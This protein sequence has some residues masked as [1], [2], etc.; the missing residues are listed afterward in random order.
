MLTHL[1]RVPFICAL[2]LL[3]VS[4]CP[5][6]D[7][8]GQ[9]DAV[10]LDSRSLPAEAMLGHRQS[11]SGTIPYH[12]AVAVSAGGLHT[13][14]LTM[15]GGVKC[16]GDNYY[17]QLGDGT[18]AWG[19]VSN[20]PVDVVG[21][22][23]GVASV[24][25]SGS[26][27]S[28]HTCALTSSG[29][30]K[31]WGLNYS[32]E[33]GDGTTINRA[34]PVDVVGLASD[35]AQLD[36]GGNYTCATTT[37][38]GIKCWGE[39][40]NGQLGDGTSID[41]T[42]PVDVVGLTTGAQ[43]VSAGRAHACAVTSSGSVKCWGSNYAGEL[44]DGTTIDRNTPVDVIG[45]GSGVV[46]VSAAMLHT[47]ALTSSGGVK[48][49]GYN[50]SGELGDGTT[51]SRSTPVDV[52]GLTSG[53]TA[54][55]SGAADFPPYGTGYTCA[56][57]LRGEIKCWGGNG[58]GQLGDGTTISRTM[59]VDVIGLTG[60]VE[61]VTTGAFHT[62]AVTG[63]HQVWCWGSNGAG[64]L[65]N[66]M[67]SNFRT[68]PT[69]TVEMPTTAVSVSAGG[70]DYDGGGHSCALTATS[71]V[72]CWGRNLD[73]ELGDGT[74]NSSDIPVDVVGLA[75]GVIAMTTGRDHACALTVGGGVKCWGNN[76]S[77]QLGDGTWSSRN[78]PVDVVG[79]ASGVTAVDAGGW[80]TCAL[81]TSRGIKCWGRNREGQLGDGTTTSRRT[82]ADVI[83][84][85]SGVVA[86]SSGSTHTCALIEGGGVRC[87]GLNGSGELGD[88][89]TTSRNTPVD[90]VGLP[91]G[92]VAVSA[93]GRHT[94][95][96]MT[97]GRV[98]C[99]GN[100]FSISPVD[101][102]GLTTGVAAVSTG[103]HHT[104]A[105]TTTGAVKCWGK[106]AFGRLG[107]GT[108]TDRATPV[109]VV[110]LT[111]EMIA[112]SAGGDHTCG[113]SSDRQ[114]LCWGGN[115]FGQPGVDPGWTPGPVSG[116]RLMLPSVM[117]H[118]FLREKE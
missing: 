80:Y 62:C 47:C 51:T 77:G 49:W 85:E 50:S 99:W 44:G 90:V 33:L 36:T 96:L 115:Y 87:W 66:G 43:S 76:I 35:V 15:T 74:I 4:M 2:L 7:V 40:G 28:G 31:C 22:T 58:T 64:Q 48:C 8:R 17:G 24:S 79:L 114:V 63:N 54:V 100:G 113:V 52:I 41:Q 91:D 71:G 12:R 112:I 5:I 103:A 101:V 37:I 14:M 61:A 29:G 30:I 60:E 89:T 98:M 82:P 27:W 84:L 45:L 72:K 21:L 16:W 70:S 25:A 65:G 13:C 55:H 56:L 83:G 110:R 88:G 81:T 108:M 57:T 75:S 93:G 68:T 102:A 69:N 46:A 38:G 18:G 95:A 34:T 59:P 97:G 78:T 73:G 23:S 20:R 53:V 9:I 117:S 118:G 6:S 109:D 104:C 26:G 86:V 111:V 3:I 94:C 19:Q 42:M 67:I 107:D 105:L 1:I 10:R 39:N 92:V 11:P 106:N 116:V 32:G